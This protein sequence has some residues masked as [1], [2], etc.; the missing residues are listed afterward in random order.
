MGY[1]GGDCTCSAPSPK[2]DCNIAE[3]HLPISK[4]GKMSHFGAAC[5]D[6]YLSSLTVGEE[7]AGHLLEQLKNIARL[8]VPGKRLR[9][10]AIH[11]GAHKAVHIGDHD[12]IGD[13]QS[14]SRT[15]ESGS[16]LTLFPVRPHPR[17]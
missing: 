6:I 16:R 1:E 9:Y 11:K 7:V 8:T 2:K 14:S 13:K 10:G 4:E 5:Q 17:R 15:P 3:D 12:D